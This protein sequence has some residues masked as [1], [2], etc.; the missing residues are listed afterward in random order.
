MNI[1]SSLN[2][3][4]LK[5]VRKELKRLLFGE[6]RRLGLFKSYSSLMAFCVLPLLGFSHSSY[7]I[8][9]ST[10]I[11]PLAGMIAPLLSE[12]DHLEVILKPGAS[13][14]GFQLK[15]SDLKTLQQSDLV[16]WVGSPVDSWMQKPLSNLKGNELSIQAL[17]DIEELAIRQGGLWEKKGHQH[18]HSEHADEHEGLEHEIRMDGHL[19]VSVHNAQRLVLAVSKQLQ[20]LKPEQAGAIE[21][22]T[23]AWLLQLADTDRQIVNQLQPVKEVPFMVLHDAFQYF[24]H[25]YDL[26]GIGSIQLNP[27]VSPSLKRVAELR[28][29]IKQGDVRCVF[30][31][32]QFPAKRVL[33]VTKGL[34]VQVG[35]LDPIGLV[36]KDYQ[37][38]NDAD[39]L[40]YDVF[41]KQLAN[42]F[43]DC[44][45]RPS[46]Q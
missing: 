13:P 27:S 17:V 42:Q 29:K 16:L 8:N 14:H 46:A 2:H 1:L 32:P 3:K 28:E 40:P 12:E 15:P 25:R 34:D 19:W 18:K 24:E 31:E 5:E 4:V 26:N 21:Q 20:L 45:A 33:A 39:Y 44:L 41:L 43:Y 36:S 10:S 23:Q 30:K 22:R 38:K 7:A 9:I 6:K 35:S 37:Q 11:P